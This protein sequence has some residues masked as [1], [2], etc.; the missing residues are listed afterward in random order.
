MIDVY[1]QKGGQEPNTPGGTF[2]L[3][4]TVFLYAEIRDSLNQTVP[5]QLVGFEFKYFN[6]TSVPWTEFTLVQGTNASG[7]ADVTTRIPP[8]S[9]YAGTWAVYATTRYNDIILI[10]TL[11]FVANRQ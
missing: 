9:E 5:N 7:I 6:A 8:V 4:D 11:T 1:T 3:N 2:M 10:D